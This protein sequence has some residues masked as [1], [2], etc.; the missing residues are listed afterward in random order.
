MK[1]FDTVILAGMVCICLGSCNPSKN[2][3][4]HPDEQE[5]RLVKLHYE[6]A[7]GEKAV[8]HFYYDLNEK[9]YLAVWHLQDSSRSSV[10]Y[11]TLD[12]AGRILVK[13]RE[14][15]DGI[16]SVRHFEYDASGNLVSEDFSRSDSVEGRVDYV[17]SAEGKLDYADCAGLSGWFYGKIKYSWEGDRKA[18]ADIIR[19]SVSIGKISYLYEED[20][21]VREKWDFNGEWNQVFR[22]EYQQAMPVTY[23][24]SNVFIRESPWFRIASEYYD[25]NGESG[26][27]SHYVYD[28][29]GKIVS[30]EFIRSDG[31]RTVSTYAYDTAG[32]LESSHR[33]YHEGGTTDFLYW[34]SVERKLLVKTFKWSDG[35]AGSETYRYRGGRLSRGEYINVDKWLNGIIDFSYSDEGLF[36]A[37]EYTGD[38]GNNAKISF[39]YDRNFNLEKIHWDFKSGHTQTY[40]Y[41]Y[42]LY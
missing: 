2:P 24:S 23:T 15:S 32:L 29:E 18:G 40:L 5:Y 7:G 25:F 8:T 13:Y 37:A 28:T 31:L 26:G 14:F 4:P 34:Y 30:K 20:R 11:H 21:L 19:D 12:S 38:D 39:D 27:P 9:N 10:N 6:N 22:Y 35:A 17:Y 33:E 41:E 3:I 36:M 42:E 16:T 1:L